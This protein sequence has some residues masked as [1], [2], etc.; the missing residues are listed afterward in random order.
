MTKVMKDTPQIKESISQETSCSPLSLQLSNSNDKDSLLFLNEVFTKKKDDYLGFIKSRQK[1]PLIL[2]FLEN[3]QNSL[4]SKIKLLDLL[5]KLFKDYPYLMDVLSS[6]K[7]VENNTIGVIL[8]NLYLQYIFTP[9]NNENEKDMRGQMKEKVL[10]MLSLFVTNMDFSRDVYDYAYSYLSKGFRNE[11]EGEITSLNMK[12]YLKLLKKLY[13]NVSKDNPAV[14]PPQLQKSYLFF[15]ENNLIETIF[16]NP[17]PVK[18]KTFTCHMWLYLPL[19][20]EILKEATSTSACMTLFEIQSEKEIIMKVVCENNMVNVIVSS[21]TKALPM[22]LWIPNDEWVHLSIVLSNDKTKTGTFIIIVEYLTMDN[23]KERFKFG[24]CKIIEKISKIVLLENFIGY[25]TNIIC[26]LANFPQLKK[27]KPEDKKAKGPKKEKEYYVDTS[28]FYPYFPYG[29]EKKKMLKEFSCSKNDNKNKSMNEV[30]CIEN[31][32][33]LYSPFHYNSREQ[34]FNDYIN[35]YTGKLKT[36]SIM[37]NAHLTPKNYKHIAN[38]GGF[39]QF[40]PILELLYTKSKNN[41]ALEE[42]FINDEVFYDYLDLVLKLI[43]NSKHN[44]ND[45]IYS[46]FFV[47]LSLF[48]EKLSDKVFN[49]KILNLFLS[50]FSSCFYQ[51]RQ[52]LLEEKDEKK[53]KQVF[54]FID[55]ILLN[56]KIL[57]KF[58]NENQ[59]KLINSIYNEI[60]LY[61]FDLINFLSFS[62]IQLIIRL[63]DRHRFEEFCCKL[64]SSM[65]NFDSKVLNNISSPEMKHKLSFYEKSI[66]KL[67]EQELT[68]TNGKEKELTKEEKEEFTKEKFKNILSFFNMLSLDL[69]PCT[70]LFI[71][72]V[73]IHYFK[74]SK[75]EKD[76]EKQRELQIQLIKNKG[77]DIILYVLSVSLIDV[78]RKILKLFYYLVFHNFKEVEPLLEMNLTSIFQI[79]KQYIIPNNLQMD[80]CGK[81]SLSQST[82]VLGDHTYSNI[83]CKSDIKDIPK[84]VHK[85]TS[86][87]SIGSGHC[88]SN[89]AINT[90]L[91]KIN[92]MT[93]SITQSVEL[94]VSEEDNQNLKDIN[95]DSDDSDEDDKKKDDRCN[96]ANEIKS[97]FKINKKDKDSKFYL[98]LRI[99]ALAKHCIDHIKIKKKN[100]NYKTYHDTQ[101]N[102]PNK[103]SFNPPKINVDI[104]DSTQN[105]NIP[106]NQINTIVCSNE[107]GS[108]FQTPEVAAKEF[109]KIDEVPYTRKRLYYYFEKDIYNYHVSLLYKQ[110]FYWLS[111]KTV[112]SNETFIFGVFELLLKIAYDSR[113]IYILQQFLEDIHTILNTKDETKD[114]KESKESVNFY[115]QTVKWI[116]QSETFYQFIIE[117]MFLSTM[118]I[119]FKNYRIPFNNKLSLIELQEIAH[120]LYFITRTL[121]KDLFVLPKDLINLNA[122]SKKKKKDTKEMVP[123]KPPTNYLDKLLSWGIY[124]KLLYEYSEVKK[125]SEIKSVKILIDNFIRLLLEDCIE[126]YQSV[127]LLNEG[128]EEN[129]FI[130]FS[131]ILYE[132]ILIYNTSKDI[133]ESDS[134]LLNPQYDGS[135][136]IY[137]P[138]YITG[139][140][141]FVIS[142]GKTKT[143]STIWSDFELINDYFTS[144]E[145]IWSFTKLSEKFSNIIIKNEDDKVHL[146]DKIIDQFI[147]RKASSKFEKEIN[148]F[149]ITSRGNHFELSFLKIISNLLTTIVSIIQDEKDCEQWL[150]KYEHFLTFLI[151]ASTV[152]YRKAP[153]NHIKNRSQLNQ[154]IIFGFAF[155]LDKIY[156]AKVPFIHFFK[157]TLKWITYIT[158]NIINLY[159]K[160]DSKTGIRL[161]KKNCTE[162]PIIKLFVEIIKVDDKNIFEYETLLTNPKK[163]ISLIDK[164]YDTNYQIW[165]EKVFENEEVSNGLKLVFDKE[166]YQKKCKI[167]YEEIANYIPL[168]D[169]NDVSSILE[170]GVKE[171]NLKLTNNYIEKEAIE[172]RKKLIESINNTIKAYNITMLKNQK[173]SSILYKTKKATYR[174]V[175]K[176]LFSWNSAWSDKTVFYKDKAKLREKLIVHYTKEFA[177]PILAPILDID[178]YLPKFSSFDS[179]TLFLKNKNNCG[180]RINLDIDE[181]LRRDNNEKEK[182][183]SS[184]NYLLNIYRYINNGEMWSMYDKLRKEEE[185]EMAFEKYSNLEPNK[186]YYKCCMVKQT[187]HVV[188]KIELGEKSVEFTLR[189]VTEEDEE[190]KLYDTDRK[191][192]SGSIFISHYKDRDFVNLKLVYS[193]I[194]FVLVRKYFYR[195]SALEIYTLENKS[196]YFNFNNQD[197]RDR[198]LKELRKKV[199]G[200][201]IKVQNRE[202]KVIGFINEKMKKL[203]SL[204]IFTYFTK[205][206]DV[207]EK[208]KS[209]QISNYEMLMWANILGNRSYRDLFQYPVFPWPIQNFSTDKLKKVVKDNNKEVKVYP[210][211]LFRNLALPMG[212]LDFD[213]AARDR[214]ELYK[215]FLENMQKEG[216]DDFD[217]NGT[218]YCYGS[219]F[220]NPMYVSH[221]LVRIFPYSLVQIEMQGSKFDDP[222]RLFLSVENSWKCVASQKC[223]IRELTP[224]FFCL[225]EMYYNINNLDM[226]LANPDV[227]LPKFSKNKGYELTKKVRKILENKDFNVN[228]WIDLIFGYLQ[229]GKKAEEHYNVYM[230]Y[231]YDGNINLD[232]IEDKGEIKCNLR[233]F[234]LGVMPTQ[235]V[236]EPISGRT[237]ANSDFDIFVFEKKEKNLLTKNFTKLGDSYPIAFYNI[238]KF[239]HILVLDNYTRINLEIRNTNFS[240]FSFN[241]T[242]VI[243]YI[244]PDHQLHHK[245]NNFYQKNESNVILARYKKTPIALY[246]KGDVIAQ[247]GYFGGEIIVT[248]IS[249]KITKIVKSVF[250][251]KPVVCLVID[252]A[253]LYAI[254]GD[255]GGQIVIYFNLSK[256]EWQFKMA[257]NDHKD[258][259]TSI[260]VDNHLNAVGTAS[261]DGYIMI[262]TLGKFKLVRSIKIW[263]EDPLNKFTYADNIFLSDCPLPCIVIYNQ[264]VNKYQSF[265]INGT[266]IDISKSKKKKSSNLYMQ[267]VPKIKQKK[268]LTAY[269][270]FKDRKNYNDYLFAG[271]SDGT[272][273]LRTF[274]AMKKKQ[275]FKVFDNKPIRL[276]ELSLKRDTIAL[277]VWTEGNEYKFIRFLDYSISILPQND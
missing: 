6:C 218:P 159:T 42:E 189:K 191:T 243:K 203:S 10:Q 158:V 236:L 201:D 226:S 150:L 141:R 86:L 260:F 108:S 265:T 192:C 18:E 46:N 144:I 224:E 200:E 177:M 176:K 207:I 35:Y 270:V 255:T 12:E 178:Y 66:L 271:Y 163:S 7:S 19:P 118:I 245:I 254:A 263:N 128:I 261:Y 155:L 206:N 87:E 238:E 47:S 175:K 37:V 193:K 229:R 257:I 82:L 77:I 179:Q 56:E 208:W 23:N 54:S 121:H 165:K 132:Y 248:Q 197:E 198:V 32:L 43:F 156:I 154:I 251:K 5:Y 102:T 78:K 127:S 227:E 228:N 65:F 169:K 33:F 21:G 164:Y 89:D 2:S 259:I 27:E 29:F 17:I 80:F 242:N 211:N 258:E 186:T 276:M 134:A 167:R 190:D 92:S 147:D 168:F 113:H 252:K 14:T 93:S 146:L 266:P 24:T 205:I 133:K 95:E 41:K 181:V 274:P 160:I 217:V 195:N 112:N 180:Y 137:Y 171:F 114:S 40:L 61:P 22:G 120:Q 124:E 125:K 183:N 36:N 58:S 59:A 51:Y 103:L 223:D 138:D 106:A 122:K 264:E 45:A 11:L 204:N 213:E 98:S 48:L 81:V 130:Q 173:E 28:H 246:Q 30:E 84:D 123:T 71:I 222:H 1:L 244:P 15:S 74:Q 148:L 60:D 174:K 249:K 57:L 230:S 142:P 220:S 209:H 151:I 63:N 235:I 105:K 119:N 212:M 110:I 52:Y 157:R 38:I 182:E 115:E 13:I 216:S 202:D 152:Q 72:K 241:E 53:K 70:Q 273:Q 25:C 234:E 88:K 79:I 131:A 172:E 247:G 20:N 268:K 31:A 83:L 194:S 68:K 233:L 111:N 153:E 39:N 90:E 231:A 166:S 96:G 187:H 272:I 126:Y 69:S 76:P 275:K 170:K 221:Y 109:E 94:N 136:N 215:Q 196:Y 214:K 139:K 67:I 4:Y 184:E 16:D 237:E 225:S 239:Y 100:P 145:N 185:D 188:G 116:Y 149:F 75:R 269:C 256:I 101:I 253:E 8:V 240:D 232:K 85:T 34:F 277:M 73:F 49:T 140:L 199:K 262:Y 62:K 55:N 3:E 26:F 9:S 210:P 107:I 250:S 91:R 129:N 161:A 162:C 267:S 99:K 219:H 97:Y 135:M 44:F 64:H 143:L 50:C 117:T 104:E